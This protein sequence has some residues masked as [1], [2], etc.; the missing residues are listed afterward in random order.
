MQIVL[1]DAAHIERFDT[2]ILADAMI[3]M[4]DVIA[5]VDL[6]KVRNALFLRRFL[7]EFLF[8]PAEDVLFGYDDESRSGQFEAIRER[9]HHD[10]QIGVAQR[11]IARCDGRWYA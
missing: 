4:D 11:L 6:A 2:Q 10:V 3:H 9:A 5:D 8:L 1:L 7:R